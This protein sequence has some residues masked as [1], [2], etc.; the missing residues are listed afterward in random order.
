MTPLF[1]GKKPTPITTNVAI[2][3]PRVCP[4]C[5]HGIASPSV[6]L[7]H[8]VSSP[9]GWVT[10]GEVTQCPACGMAIRAIRDNIRVVAVEFVCPTCGNHED[11]EYRI[12]EVSKGDR[13][14][15]G[16]EF[17]AQISCKTCVKKRTI[18]EFTKSIS[19]VSQI[20]V[21]PDSIEFKGG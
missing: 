14:K 18:R 3:K 11:L 13:G 7:T 2:P 19:G 8:A 5:L 4:C 12:S 6:T 1:R 21:N 20:N 9:T 10:K 17:E 15:D 16:Y